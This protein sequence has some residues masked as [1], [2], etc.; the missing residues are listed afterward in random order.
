MSS[1]LVILYHH[2]PVLNPFH[3]PGSTPDFLS[4]TGK[5]PQ[6][7]DVMDNG[8][9]SILAVKT[10]DAAEGKLATLSLQRGDGAG[11]N[12]YLVHE[13]AGPEPRALD[14]LPKFFFI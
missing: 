11:K 14:S 1:V 9:I 12:S 5:C 3:I 2:K 8:S 10:V 4:P 6:V 7:L 13:R